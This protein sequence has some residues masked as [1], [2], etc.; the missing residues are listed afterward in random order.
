MHRDELVARCHYA[1]E[2][3]SAVLSQLAMAADLCAAVLDG[4]APQAWARPVRYHFPELTE[5]GLGWV[6]RHT[7]H[8]GQ[9][10]LMDISRGLA[11]A[12]A[13]GSGAPSSAPG[14]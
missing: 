14:I 13:G 7:I 10:H 5:R 11:A 9:H 1:A 6:G 12:D 2:P 4:L 8:E 3:L